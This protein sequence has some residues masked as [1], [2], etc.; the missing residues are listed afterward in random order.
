MGRKPQLDR[1][2]F[3]NRSYTLGSY[4]VTRNMEF[5]K[6]TGSP[7][8]DVDQSFMSG[9]RRRRNVNRP[10]RFHDGPNLTDV[11]VT[12]S[13]ATSN[14]RQSLLDWTTNDICA[15]CQASSHLR[16][17][18]KGCIKCSQVMNMSAYM[19]LTGFC[20]NLWTRRT[21]SS[22]TTFG[23]RLA[24]ELSD[25]RKTTKILKGARITAAVALADIIERVLVGEDQSWERI[26][27]FTTEA[28]SKSSSSD[29]QS[30]QSLTAAMNTNIAQFADWLTFIIVDRAILPTDT[31]RPS[32]RSTDF[33]KVIN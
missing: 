18:S 2:P 24:V 23:W 1:A 27:R 4:Y 9:R 19:P 33:R 28:L 26:I 32:P 8:Q 30:R 6:Q 25:K 11:A 16:S 29:L 22:N 10:I 12:S 31:S 5:S 15:L 20:H 14:E 13:L 3:T 7:S 17:F 21:P